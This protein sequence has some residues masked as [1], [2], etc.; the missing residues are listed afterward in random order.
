[1]PGQGRWRLAQSMDCYG[2]SAEKSSPTRGR[3]SVLCAHKGDTKSAGSLSVARVDKFRLPI[4]VFDGP[5]RSRELRAGIERSYNMLRIVLDCNQQCSRRSVRP[6]SSLFPISKRADRNMKEARKL[7]L[8]Q[9]RALADSRDNIGRNLKGPGWFPVTT[10]YLGCLRGAFDQF[11]KQFLVHG[12][13]VY[14]NC[15][16]IPANRRFCPGARSSMVR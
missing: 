16:T 2:G 4:K 15:L 9:S 3:S 14:F 10:H 5:N 6:S 7:L 13:N 11:V 12:C 1:M 8:G